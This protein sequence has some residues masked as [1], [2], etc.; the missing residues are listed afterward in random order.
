MQKSSACG[1]V[2]LIIIL[3]AACG[4]GGSKSDGLLGPANQTVAQ[5][6]VPVAPLSVNA[7][8]TQQ[9][10]ATP[11]NSS[12]QV[13]GATLTYSSSNATLAT[14]SPAGLVCGGTWDS[15]FANCAAASMSGSA[16]ITVSASGVSSQPVT[17]FVH[18]VVAS[19]TVTPT[20]GCTSVGLTQQY[21]AQA[22]D[23]GSNDITSLVGG[24]N[25]ALEKNGVGT[26]DPILGLATAVTPGNA[27][28]T[29]TVS[30]VASPPVPF[31]VCMPVSILLHLSSDSPGLPTSSV[32]M[33]IGQTL[34]L[35]ADMVDQ[36]GVRTTMASLPLINNNAPVASVDSTYTLAALSPGGVGI[37][38]ACALPACGKEVNQPVYS[39]LFSVTVT[40]TS[41]PTTVFATS[42]VTPPTGTPPS[43]I[44]INSSTGTS[45]PPIP[46]P[47][48]PNSFQFVANGASAF[49]GTSAGLVML[50]PVGL[51]ATVVSGDAIGKVLAVSPSGSKVLTAT[52]TQFVVYNVASNSA[53]TFLVPN[54]VAA[55]FDADGSNAY[56]A[57]SDGTIY[58]YEGSLGL[59]IFHLAGSP[60]S[61][62]ALASGPFVYIVN[63][64]GLNVMATC[65]NSM[66]AS[67]TTSATPQLV[68]STLNADK[69][70][71][72]GTTGVD[73]ETVTVTPLP[74][75]ASPTN[76]FCPPTVSYNDQFLDFGVGAFV[77]RQVLVAS[78]AN[79][80]VVIP[81]GFGEV[82]AVNGAT[83]SAIPLASAATEA[84][85]GGMTLDGNTAWV[86]VGGTN[87]VDLIDLTKNR[88]AQ[89]VPMPFQKADGTPTPPDLVAVRPQ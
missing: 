12:G 50:D 49:L 7:G 37:I 15:A 28:V 21:A 69:V 38:A 40:G 34:A 19:V 9:L 2:V 58:V 82:L 25:W 60:A 27:L 87:S 4:G 79:N 57:A 51:T 62:V 5:I 18:P 59:H 42:S 89:Q 80:I 81:A 31:S 47:G 61:V 64:G 23:A 11:Q 88:D 66:Q 35:E 13:V 33:S 45:G 85:S 41:P 78:G 54:V 73:I 39:N 53:S 70:M 65:D 77:A 48:V 24:F 84:F 86:G 3:L 46:L 6:V 29:A 8:G 71:A 14:V 43:V 17:V 32:T 56:V 10:A 16:T 55:A 52:S 67:V 76:I 30:N 36:N 26:I 83:A 75:P 72:V 68:G 1:L 20:P 63:T 22:F 74:A 44:P